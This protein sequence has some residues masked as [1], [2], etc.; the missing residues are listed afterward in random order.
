MATK[1][2]YYPER[3]SK[4]KT[5]PAGTDFNEMLEFLTN[6]E[7]IQTNEYQPEETNWIGGE[8][9]PHDPVCELKYKYI[10]TITQV[11]Q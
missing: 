2:D 6:N 4:S 7:I 11:N 8:P 9:G 10:L 3:F 1:N 5:F